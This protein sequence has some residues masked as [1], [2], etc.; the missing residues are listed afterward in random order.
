MEDLPY[1]AGTRPANPGLLSRFLPVLEEGTISTWLMARIPAG[2]WILDPFGSS[3]R[4]ALE[5]ARA[6]YRVL[7]TANNPITRFLVEMAASI[8]AEL[9]L[10]AALAELAAARKSDERLETHLQS[11]YLTPCEKCGQQVQ[12]QAFLWNKGD[13]TPYARL[14]ECPHC[15][16]SGERPATPFDLERARELT[17]SASLHRARILERVAPVG[18]PD[19]EY[20]E[21]A[22]QVYL[23]RAV[24]ALATLINRV[25]GL[26]ITP[27]R[28]RLI[29]ALSLAAFDAGTSLW[30]VDRPRPKQLSLSNQFRE[31]N[32]W[33]A[34]EQAIGQWSETGAGVSLEAWPKK[35]PETGGI[36]LFDGRLKDLA[37][38]VRKE[39]PIAAVVGAVPR[40]NQ[41]FWTLSA[42]WAGWLWGQEA[43]EP[44]K[45]GLRRRRYDWAWNATA[46]SSTLHHLSGLLPQGTPMLAL[47]AEPEAPF[48]T[49]A[50]TAAESSGFE[51]GG[52]ALRDEQ[53]PLQTV[54]LRRDSSPAAFSRELAPV[55]EA[56]EAHLNA[57]AE[58]ASYLR[59]HL[60]ALA[61]LTARHALRAPEEPLD[62]ALRSTN[63][64]IEMAV[65]GDAPLLHY[66]QGEGLETGFWGLRSYASGQDSLADRVEMT[67]VRFLQKNPDRIFLEIEED[68]Y[69]QFRSLLTPSKGLVYNVLYSYAQRHGGAWRLREEDMPSSRRDDLQHMADL[70]ESVGGRLGYS[71]RRDGQALIWERD[72]ATER[73]FYV[74]ASA[75]VGRLVS[76]NTHPPE[77]CVIVLPG[78]RASLAAY[79]QQRD[80][81]L[82]EQ[83]HPWRLLKYRLLRS[84]AGIPVLNRQTFEEQMTSDPVEQAQGQ[85][86]MF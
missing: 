33:M 1:L 80:P 12:A 17:R 77:K 30:A 53:D 85:L 28:R 29:T 84:L 27:E 52:L 61:K 51:L 22:L 19:R 43:A 83:M 70:L 55:R 24:Y 48:A 23:P 9:E 2:S 72:E 49:S 37:D 16:D 15:E 25:D 79:K 40:P 65:S 69:T 39:I 67:I 6:G 75:L 68:L 3:P 63:T 76:A 81:A 20:A 78:G 46:L 38:Q 58:P 57:R 56:I 44:F 54:W 47:L 21:E 64:L 42:L 11:L 4:T 7:V 36:C 31:R 8:P 82:A 60:S 50:F 45:I 62:E 5:V 35:I 74:I 32:L 18:D 26:D 71:T 10:K 14:Y 13:E 41:A 34:L 59:I 73:V 66:S 86:M